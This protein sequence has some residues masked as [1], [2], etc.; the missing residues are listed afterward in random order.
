VVGQPRAV[1]AI[2]FGI[3]IREDG[4]TC[5]R[6]ARRRGPAHDRQALPGSR[7]EREPGAPDW[8]YV[9]DFGVP[10]RPRAIA[11]RREGA[12]FKR[13]IE[14]LVDDLRT[15]IPPRSRPTIP[16][17]Q[18]GD[19]QRLRN[20]RKGDPGGRRARIAT[21]DRAPAHAGGF[22]FAPLVGD[23]VMSPDKFTPCRGRA[24][25]H[26]AGDRGTAGR[27]AARDR[28]HATWRREAQHKLRDL[29]RQVTRGAISTLIDEVRPLARSGPVE[30]YLE[31]VRRMSSTTRSCSCSQGAEVEA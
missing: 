27:V 5:S 18:A 29:D 22:G 10:H 14:R 15:G 8:C 20:G 3:G 23:E 17:A 12:A 30:R 13:D 11:L 4:T 21:E 31:E 2:G 1:E 9:F 6:W 25:A 16:H 7:G 28:E 19:R 26:P 24:E